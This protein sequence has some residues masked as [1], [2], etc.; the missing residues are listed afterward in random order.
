MIVIANTF[1][2]FLISIGVIFT[3]AAVIGILRLPDIYTRSHAAT[4]SATFGVSC[5]LT[6]AFFYFWI[7]EGDFN[8]KLLLGILFLLFTAP[9]GGHV[10]ARA[11]YVSGVKPYES[12]A[13]DE[14]EKVMNND[15]KENKS[16][17]SIKTDIWSKKSK[18]KGD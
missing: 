9:L 6:G 17:D 10:I 7:F 11:A 5:I 1:I 4:K 14:L 13:N 18:V 2:I 12:T 15:K 8:I 3:V 16:D